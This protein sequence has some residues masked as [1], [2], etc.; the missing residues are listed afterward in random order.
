MALSASLVT[1]VAIRTV[2]QEQAG[3]QIECMVK[4]CPER[5]RGQAGSAASPAS[6]PCSIRSTARALSV[7]PSIALMIVS[8]SPRD[9]PSS[10]SSFAT[11]ADPRMV[12]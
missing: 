1:P 3:D 11:S 7:R 6:W 8:R 10:K 9:T 2:R 5:N 12:A 4:S